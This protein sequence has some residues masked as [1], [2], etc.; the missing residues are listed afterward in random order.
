MTTN[1]PGF[2]QTIKV[3][4]FLPGDPPIDI[5]DIVRQADSGATPRILARLETDKPDG[6][7]PPSLPKFFSIARRCTHAGCNILKGSPNWATADRPIVFSMLGEGATVYPVIQCPCHGSRFDLT[8]G[9]RLL[10]PAPPGANLAQ[11][12]TRI[13]TVGEDAYVFVALA[14]T[15]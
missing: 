15:A 7:Q 5:T 2:V 8:S 10:G 12:E 6:E 11:F 3:N 13:E 9:K 1:I 14:A 4:D